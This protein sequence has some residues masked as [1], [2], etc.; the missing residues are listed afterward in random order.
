M[1]DEDRI[2]HLQGEPAHDIDEADAAALDDLRDLLRDPAVWAEPPG[3]LDDRVVAA[4]AAESS[5]RPSLAAAP[6]PRRM[7]RRAWVAGAVAAAAVVVAAVLVTG[8]VSDSGGASR[9]R[10]QVALAAVGPAGPASTVGPAGPASTVGPA[11]PSG[12]GS[13][14]RTDAGWRIELTISDLPRLDNGAYYQAWLKNDAGLLVPIGTFNQGGRVT[15]WAGVSPLDFPTVTV[16]VEAADGN[17][18]SSGQRV[19]AGTAKPPS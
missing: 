16:T 17:Q 6:A 9:T 7:R 5:T 1:T 2:A 18:A 15:L 19:L 12:S 10:L 11:G 13:L 8:V 14:T 3:D 4:I